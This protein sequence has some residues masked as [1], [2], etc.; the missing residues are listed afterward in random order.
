MSIEWEKH[1]IEWSKSPGTTETDRIENSIRAVRRAIS[2][3]NKLSAVSK[4][5]LQGSYRNRVNVR[6][7]S[8]VDI[9]VLYTGGS[10]IPDYPSGTDSTTFGNI[11]GTYNQFQFKN[12]VEVALVREFGRAAVTRGNKAIDVKEN[13]YRVEADVVPVF[14]G[15]RYTAD[16]RYICGVNLLTDKGESINNWPEKILD[17]PNWPDQHYE[18]GLNKNVR[19]SRRYRSQVRI[20]KKLLVVMNDAK[21]TEADGIAGFLVECLVYNAPEWTLFLDNWHTRTI[22]TLRYLVE[23][24]ATDSTCSEWCEV[25]G[26]KWL[27][28]TEIGKRQR[29]NTFL[30]AALNLINN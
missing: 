19:T 22:S 1:F 15:R 7:D 26:Y 17:T 14:E 27:F 25:S 18:N 8:D 11:T 9:G 5:F 10:F 12:D 16:G 24:T 20:I 3:D 30:I 29:A 6:N 23:N 4:V 28:K 21:M 13:T 2:V